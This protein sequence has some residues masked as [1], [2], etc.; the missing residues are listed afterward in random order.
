MR[1]ISAECGVAGW[2]GRGFPECWGLGSS[3]GGGIGDSKESYDSSEDDRSGTRAACAEERVAMLVIGL[4]GNSGHGEVGAVNGD[5]GGLGEA[6]GG[7][8][9]LDGRVDG[10][11]GDDDCKQKINRNCS[12]QALI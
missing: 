12:Y 5:H 7:V 10:S 6:S 11:G 8:V 1:V 9:F 3:A 4:H 2:R